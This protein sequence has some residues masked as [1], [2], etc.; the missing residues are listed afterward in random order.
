M[1]RK[2]NIN[3][4]PLEALVAARRS[5]REATEA[6]CGIMV[7]LDHNAPHDESGAFKSLEAAELREYANEFSA[8][9]GQLSAEFDM[10]MVEY[11]GTLLHYKTMGV[12]ETDADIIAAACPS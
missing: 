1:T 9:L 5:M 12:A 6:V 11:L 10:E 4:D 2:L 8:K 7:E 3:I